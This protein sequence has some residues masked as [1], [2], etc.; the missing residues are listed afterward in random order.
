MRRRRSLAEFLIVLFA[1][2][3]QA[4]PAISQAPALT[5]S[6]GPA[7]QGWPLRIRVGNLLDD[8][9]LRDALESALPL[10]FH[11]RAELW[12]KRT[13]DRLVEAEEISVALLQDPL[14]AGYSLETG[15]GVRL[16]KTLG[17]A[18]LALGELLNPA[19]TPRMNGRHYYIVTLEVETLSLSDLDELR[20]WLRGDVAPAIGG[21][22]SP[23]R[24][25]E[26]GLRRL[27]VR[28]IGLPT[29][30]FE[31]RTGTFIRE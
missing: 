15:A 12:R 26:R 5:L 19:L 29:R 21:Q 16:V 2:L 30:R 9:G 4:Q 3:A 20:R 22:S 27:M 13:L 11:M 31:A 14:G 17:E 18:Q 1:T 28:V 10:R 23:S 7:D 24:A 8:S 6:V 25:V